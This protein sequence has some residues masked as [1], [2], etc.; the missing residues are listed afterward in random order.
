MKRLE[1]PGLKGW[2]IAIETVDQLT[3]ARSLRR[4][5]H[6]CRNNGFRPGSLQLFL[7]LTSNTV[8]LVEWLKGAGSVMGAALRVLS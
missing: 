3:T 1:C 6:T 5:A 2:I 7:R 4:Y 8:I